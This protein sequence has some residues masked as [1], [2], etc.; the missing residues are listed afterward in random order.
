[1]SLELFGF[2]QIRGPEHDPDGE[3][4]H[5]MSPFA[6]GVPASGRKHSGQPL[7]QPDPVGD[8]PQ[9]HGPRM[10]DQSPTVPRDHQSAVPL[11]TLTHQKGVLI[12][13]P[14]ASSAVASCQVR[15][16]F[17]L[18]VRQAAQFS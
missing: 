10:P 12:L 14:D 15:A 6:P 7:D 3:L 18:P 9:Q 2:G 8:L 16:P 17:L 4:D 13:A 1:M 11:C 5:G